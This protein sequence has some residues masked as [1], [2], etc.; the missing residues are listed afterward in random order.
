MC[1]WGTNCFDISTHLVPILSRSENNIN[2]SALICVSLL[3]DDLSHKLKPKH[4]RNVVFI[5]KNS[6]VQMS[7][8]IHQLTPAKRN[9]CCH[10]ILL[11]FFT[12]I[13][14]SSVNFGPCRF[15]KKQQVHDKTCSTSLNYEEVEFLSQQPSWMGDSSF[16][17]S[18][19]LI[20][21][22]QLSC[23]SK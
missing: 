18:W 23:L 22:P 21:C 15:K 13:F 2:I 20:G 17:V 6:E 10:F 4:E 19:A 7:S 5:M 16:L 8:P 3:L 12:L 9:K 11:S 14:F 1:I